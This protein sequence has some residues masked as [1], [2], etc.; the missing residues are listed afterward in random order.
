MSNL[1]R[2][3]R[4]PIKETPRSKKKS[5]SVSPFGTSSPVYAPL[6]QQIIPP[7]GVV[8]PAIEKPQQEDQ[9]TSSS[10]SVEQSGAVRVG[11]VI[12]ID[13][14]YISLILG[15]LLH[16]WW[17][18]GESL[19]IGLALTGI[20]VLSAKREFLRAV[21]G[22]LLWFLFAL[23]WGYI[24]WLVCDSYLPLI[25]HCLCAFI[26][27]LLG[28]VGH[29]VISGVVN[30]IESK[31]MREIKYC[32]LTTFVDSLCISLVFGFLLHSWWMLGVSLL[33][34]L[35]THWNYCSFSEE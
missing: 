26:G 24:G 16:S 3:A 25:I 1:P 11:P 10:E 9:S 32:G 29:F 15:S 23:L 2:N 5:D 7:P 34:G 4:K 28:L 31:R 20:I 14:L 22:L 21:I 18:L 30:S 33:V 8:L 6:S 12:F 27:F 13:T 35:I 19:L 17:V